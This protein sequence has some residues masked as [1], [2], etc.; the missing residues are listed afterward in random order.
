MSTSIRLAAL[1][2]AVASAWA[3]SALDSRVEIIRGEVRPQ[4]AMARMREIY[5]TDRW[6]SFSKF[7]ETATYLKNAMQAAG[8]ERIEIVQAPA[9]GRSQFGF[10][11]MPLAWDATDAPR[12]CRARG[13]T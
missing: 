9:D 3:D 11:T 5:A 13:R 1:L 6:F 10:W 4:E 12:D 8:L 2:L 7:Q